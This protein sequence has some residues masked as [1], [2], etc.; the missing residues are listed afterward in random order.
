MSEETSFAASMEELEAILRRIES[1]ETDI[2]ALA[3]ELKR[4]QELL[5][6]LRSKIRRAEAEVAQI[7]GSLDGE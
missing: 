1:E 4:A 2:D 6:R 5:Q 7:V 3:T